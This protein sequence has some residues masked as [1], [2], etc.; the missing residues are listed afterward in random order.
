MGTPPAGSGE[1]SSRSLSIAATVTTRWALCD[2]LLGAT[3]V[4][5]EARRVVTR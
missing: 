4:A 2:I 5:R 3:I 1:L